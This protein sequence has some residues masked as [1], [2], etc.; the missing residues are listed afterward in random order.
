[1]GSDEASHSKTTAI[2]NKARVPSRKEQLTARLAEGKR[3]LAA[4]NRASFST[5]SNSARD[6]EPCFDT[7]DSDAKVCLLAV[8][9]VMSSSEDGFDKWARFCDEQGLEFFE[10]EDQE[11]ETLSM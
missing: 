7:V 6:P 5:N 1:M 10:P 2:T 3:L 8:K 9:R 4:T 11:P